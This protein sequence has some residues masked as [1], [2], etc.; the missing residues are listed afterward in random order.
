MGVDSATH[1]TT[2]PPY[3]ASDMERKK[4]PKNLKT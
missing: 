3:E 1:C 4:H 2:V